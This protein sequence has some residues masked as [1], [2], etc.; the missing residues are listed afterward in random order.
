[1]SVWIGWK[2]WVDGWGN[3]LIKEGGGGI[4]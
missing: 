4:I 2:G 3:T 1:M